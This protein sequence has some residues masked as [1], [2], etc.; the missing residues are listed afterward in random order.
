VNKARPEQS[1]IREKIMFCP[2]RHRVYGRACLT[3]QLSATGFGRSQMKM[4][5]MRL[6]AR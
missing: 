5:A 1:M 4:P 3:D 2:G 6:V